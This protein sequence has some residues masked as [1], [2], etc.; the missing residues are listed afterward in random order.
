VSKVIDAGDATEVAIDPM[1][2][3]S[4]AVGTLPVLQLVPKLQLPPPVATQ[5]SE[6]CASL[7]LQSLNS[8]I[9]YTT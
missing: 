9:A 5:L 6:F 3:T 8:A 7:T 1:L 2:A 4:F